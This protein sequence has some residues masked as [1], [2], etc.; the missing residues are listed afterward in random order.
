MQGA[1]GDRPPEDRPMTDAA[2]VMG[3]ITDLIVE[4]AQVDR[5]AITPRSRF[6]D[7]GLDSVDVMPVIT[8]I[9][10]RYGLT[11]DEADLAKLNTLRELARYVERRLKS[12]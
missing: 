3:V 8:R 5:A 2:E 6:S 12:A 9:E 10:E 1:E 7:F 4:V 11:I